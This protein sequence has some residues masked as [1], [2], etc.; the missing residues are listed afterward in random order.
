[1]AFT[2]SGFQKRDGQKKTKKNI[3]IFAPLAVC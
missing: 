2:N 1:M 3:E